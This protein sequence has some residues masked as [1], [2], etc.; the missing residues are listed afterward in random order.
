MCE[1]FVLIQSTPEYLVLSTYLVEERRMRYN[2]FACTFLRIYDCQKK[3]RIPWTWLSPLKYISY[4][5]TVR[6]IQTSSLYV[7][8]VSLEWSD[9]NSWF[10][11]YALLIPYCINSKWVALRFLTL[12]ASLLS[13]QKCWPTEL[14]WISA[15]PP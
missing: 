3:S 2:W 11:L 8:M 7:I 13:C 10:T 14:P 4:P 9:T 12:L 5:L 1:W 15:W 6:K